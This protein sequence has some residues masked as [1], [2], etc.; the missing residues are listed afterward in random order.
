MVGLKLDDPPQ[1]FLALL[2]Q[3]ALAAPFGQ[4]PLAV[5]RV[6]PDRMIPGRREALYVEIPSQ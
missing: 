1:M 4:R 3:V 6:A 2:D 5:D